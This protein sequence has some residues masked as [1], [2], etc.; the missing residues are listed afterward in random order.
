M[1]VLDYIFSIPCL[2]GILPDNY[3]RHW[4]L[5]VQTKSCNSFC[6]ELVKF[7]HVVAIK[8]TKK[9]ACV[10]IMCIIQQLCVILKQEE[11]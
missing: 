10:S 1:E 11:K 9:T 5:L 6:E 3:L 8:L 4:L 2:I 7:K